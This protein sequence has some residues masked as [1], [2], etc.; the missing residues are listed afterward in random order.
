MKV[1]IDVI[2]EF[3]GET[4]EKEYKEAMAN[5]YDEMWNYATDVDVLSEE[6]I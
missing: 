4:T 1:R 2:L 3:N 6:E 5:I